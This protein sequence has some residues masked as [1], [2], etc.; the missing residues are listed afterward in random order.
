MMEGFEYVSDDYLILHQNEKNEL[1]SSPIYSIITLSPK[2]YGELYSRLSGSQFVSNN[3]RKDKYVFNISNFHD[4]FKMNYPIKLCI[5][6]EIVTDPEPSIRPCTTSE[7][8]RAM[9]QL[10][11]STLMQTQDMCENWT[12]KKM[13]N[14][15]KDYP[16][17]KFNLCHNIEKNTEFL[18]EFMNNF[19]K[20]EHEIIDSDKIAID[21]TFDLANILNTQSG[22]IYFMNYFATNIY[23]NLLKGV[24]KEAIQAEL[25]QFSDE[26]INIKRDF[27]LFI[28]TLE[29]KE[30]FKYVNTNNFNAA[31]NKD[32]AKECRYKLSFVECAQEK[33]DEL[34]KGE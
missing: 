9:V 13:M 18:R 30:I 31:I 34:I 23:E 2:M 3:A 4:R 14:M 24:S 21:I 28:Q 16:Y 33:Y 17:Y 10:I 5:F 26:N 20:M 15:I 8:G 32:Y 7:K 27:E 22:I 19:N 29:E 12:V 11:Q 25:M 1:L 6:P